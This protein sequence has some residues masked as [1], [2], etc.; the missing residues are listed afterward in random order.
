MRNPF[1][2]YEDKAAGLYRMFSSREA[3]QLWYD[4]KDSYS[5]LELFNFVRP[6]DYA[7]ELN[8]LTPDARYVTKGSKNQTGAI[9]SYT[10]DVRN[11][12]GSYADS[13]T[14]T[15]SITTAIGKR[16]A[17]S[18]I[19]NS[20]QKMVEENI[21][22]YL[23]LGQN[24]VTVSFKASSTGATASISFSVVM[25]ELTLKSNFNFS[26]THP[27][28]SILTIP[29]TLN[30]NDSSSDCSVLVYIDGQ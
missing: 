22:D 28:G 10:W 15:Y 18:K 12:K 13:V 17:Y 5:D 14:V 1:F 3:W 9:L 21:Y 23:D 24:V 7:I 4:D 6:S 11:D 26:A 16:S 2:V 29:F 25:L 8:N 20:T 27:Y 30:R 19:Y